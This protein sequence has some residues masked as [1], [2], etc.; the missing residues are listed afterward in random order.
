M[1]DK[2]HLTHEQ[3]IKIEAVYADMKKKAMLLGEKFIHLEAEL[4]NSFL[5]KTITQ[6]SLKKIVRAIENVKAELRIAHLSTHLQT[7]NI[8]TDEQIILY[9]QLRGYSKDPC[10][11]IPEGH[12]MEMWKKHNGCK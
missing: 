4:N 6:A 7:P 3:K 11:N 8:L 9:N 2:I 1:E 10:Q 12:N 5:N